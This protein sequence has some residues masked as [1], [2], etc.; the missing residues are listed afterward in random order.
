MPL[1]GDLPSPRI[2]LASLMSAA[3]AGGF[4]C[5]FFCFFFFTTGATWEVPHNSVE[6]RVKYQ[7]KKRNN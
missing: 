6:N 2:E 3:L 5:F 1:P 4:F 7:T